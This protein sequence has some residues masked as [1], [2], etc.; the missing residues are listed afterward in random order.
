IIGEDV[1][2]LLGLSIALFFVLLAVITGNP[3]FDAVGSIAIGV[4]LIVIA[5][6]ITFEVKS[7][8]V[9]ESAD[10]EFKK[11]LD[12]FIAEKYPNV[13]LIN[14]I[15]QHYG[16]D[17]VLAIKARFKI[18]PYSAQALVEEINKIEVSL[19]AQF[20]AIRFIFFEPDLLPEE[21][22]KKRLQTKKRA[23]PVK[24]TKLA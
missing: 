7:L 18:W 15:T 3:V 11:S 24:R 6:I 17:I 1:A 22:K 4:L 19:R 5:T 23:K 14:V 9:G 12:S 13:I 2:A 20:S 16:N 10:D 21:K 8:I